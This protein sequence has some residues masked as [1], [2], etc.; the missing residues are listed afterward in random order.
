MPF[1][2]R[3]HYVP[4]FLPRFT[5]EGKVTLRL[6]PNIAKR[7]ITAQTRVTFQVP[8]ILSGFLWNPRFAVNVTAESHLTC[9]AQHYSAI[10]GCKTGPRSTQHTLRRRRARCGMPSRYFATASA[11]SY[12]PKPPASLYDPPPRRR[13]ARA[14]SPRLLLRAQ[15]AAGSCSLTQAAT[16]TQDSESKV[17]ARY[18]T[19]YIRGS[20]FSAVVICSGYGGGAEALLTGGLRAMLPAL[21]RHVCIPHG[22]RHP[23]PSQYTLRS[24]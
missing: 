5:P 15:A 7:V 8:A 21:R 3:S 4:G 16:G 20:E 24:P 11:S 9:K 10:L 22:A 19:T 1:R 13:R 23:H 12:F 14:G 2:Q 6:S 18:I 17:T